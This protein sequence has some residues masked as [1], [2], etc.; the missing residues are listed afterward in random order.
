MRQPRGST[1]PKGTML[2]LLP[3]SLLV[4][5]LLINDAAE[6]LPPG[7]HARVPAQLPL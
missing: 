7:A 1:L 2:L 3:A 4:C 6:T 5:G